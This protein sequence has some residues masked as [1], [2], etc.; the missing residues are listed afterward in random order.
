MAIAFVMMP[1]MIRTLGDSMYGIWAVVGSL[2]ATYYLLDLGFTAAVSRYVAKHIQEREHE[3]TN[4]TV[5]TAFAIYLGL[6]LVIFVTTLGV[7]TFSEHFVHNAEHGQTVKWLIILMGLTMAFNFPFNAFAGI[8]NAYLRYDLGV[9][10]RLFF[11]VCTPLAYFLLLSHGYK[12]LALA[13]TNLVMSLLSDVT[14][15]CI[16]RYLHPPLRVAWRFVSFDSAKI[17]FSYSIW[18]FV[19]N[20]AYTL[21]QGIYS[22]IIGAYRSASAVTHYTVGYRL[23]EYA[24]QMQLQATNILGPLFTRYHTSGNAAELQDKVVLMTKINTLLACYCG[25]MLLLLGGDFINRWMGP[26]YDD[27]YVV[28][29]ILTIGFAANLTFNPLSSAM[30]AIA[31]PK[32][33]AV[34]DML[35]AGINFLASLVLVQRYGIYGVAIGT[36]VPLVLFA[37]GPR[38]WVACKQIHMPV[39]RYY[40]AVL[41]LVFF[42]SGLVIV[43]LIWKQ[44]SWTNSYFAL[45]GLALLIL[46]PYLMLAVNLFF[47]RQEISLLISQLPMRV[48]TLLFFFVWRPR[49]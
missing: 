37:L 20:I 40:Q 31:K 32:H 49:T 11:S 33:I 39:R 14:F 10:S 2:I 27:A 45:L 42:T 38:P 3:A 22:L 47:T 13:V 43:S 16:A 26:E 18:A 46:P 9:Y 7:A 23:V 36:T 34:L 48:Q 6:G 8:A 12:L 44:P 4:R 35:E 41:P 5:S 19:T 21:R 17:L 25:W 24:T 30:F 1:F 15:V 29:C 28:L